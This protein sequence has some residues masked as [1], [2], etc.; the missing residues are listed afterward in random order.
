VKRPNKE[1]L[2][3]KRVT[4]PPHEKRTVK[5]SIPASELAFWSETRKAFH[6]QSGRFKLMVGGSSTD[7]KLARS[8]YVSARRSGR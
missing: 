6:L 2:G 4:V 1:L 5:M 7:I 8:F 3:F